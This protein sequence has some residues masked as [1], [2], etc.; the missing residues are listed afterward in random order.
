MAKTDA[1]TKLRP[2]PLPTEVTID[3]NAMA[4]VAMAPNELR[5]LKRQTGQSMTELLGDGADDADRLQVM[6]WL[7]LRRDGHRPSWDE[8]GDVAV[9][10][11]TV[12]PDPTNG[13]PPISSPPSAT[14][15]A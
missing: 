8:A 5:E 13:G 4:E 3:P 9:V 1:V 7:R 11:R 15:G 14:T 10:Y 6:V 12:V 2:E